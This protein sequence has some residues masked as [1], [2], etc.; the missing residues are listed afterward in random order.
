MEVQQLQDGMNAVVASKWSDK[1][2]GGCHLYDKEF[3]QKPD[4]FTWMNNPKFLLKLDTRD[5]VGV[6]VTLNRPEKAWKKSV[7]MDLVG[8][9]IGFYVYP[10]SQQPSKENL[11][12]REGC[13][14]V[15]W[16]EVS[17]TV[18]LEGN[19]LPQNREGY[20]IMPATQDSG[21]QGPFVLAVSTTVEFTL[22]Q[23][24]S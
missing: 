5:K 13:K 19:E 3:E 17:E 4:C 1:T 20:I 12:N 11:L 23:L 16:N 2:A 9:M 15:P 10:G 14:F 8:S 6:K 7:G 24:D 18:W 22:T 21:K